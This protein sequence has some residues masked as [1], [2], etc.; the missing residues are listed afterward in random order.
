MSYGQ[1][2]TLSLRVAAALRAS[3]V[4][5]G[6]TV[7]ILSANDPIAFSTVFGISRVGAVWSPINPRSEAADNRELLDR[8]DAK[9]LIYQESFAPMVKRIVPDL[10][11]LTTLVCLDGTD[12]A[13]TSFEDWLATG[14]SGSGRK[15]PAQVLD[16][17]Q[18]PEQGELVDNLA[19]IVGRPGTPRAGPTRQVAVV[20]RRFDLWLGSRNGHASGTCS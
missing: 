18:E 14:S 19:L 20:C 6:D 2:Q 11:Q 9:V 4:G 17:E 12:D 15:V 13:G 1:V 16:K 7:A 3:G 8:F 10:P 5:P